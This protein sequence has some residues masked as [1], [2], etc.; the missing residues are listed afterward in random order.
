MSDALWRCIAKWKTV[1]T[2]IFK[3]I[4]PW[5]LSVHGVAGVGVRG[6][7]GLGGLVGVRGGAGGGLGCGGSSGGFHGTITNDAL[8][9]N[10][11][12]LFVIYLFFLWLRLS[13]WR[14]VLM[15]PIFFR[16]SRSCYYWHF[17]VSSN[18]NILEIVVN[19]INLNKI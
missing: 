15:Q 5:Y 11:S 9:S 4:V 14:S 6:I 10:N 7:W 2:S 1:T 18:E 16:N 12:P 17:S 8:I 13:L 19:Q 3:Y